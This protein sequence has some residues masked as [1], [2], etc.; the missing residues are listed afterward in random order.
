MKRTLGRWAVGALCLASC[1]GSCPGAAWAQSDRTFRDPRF[2]EACRNLDAK[3][4]AKARE[5]AERMLAEDPNSYTA[6]YIM[7]WIYYYGDGSIPR[8]NNCFR[9]A[10]QGLEKIW[11]TRPP[12][13]G[14]FFIHQMIFQQEILSTIQMERYEE[15]LRLIED[16]GKQYA[17]MEAY[18]G[19]PLLKLGRVDEARE[20]MKLELSLARDSGPLSHALNT[21]GNLEF[22]TDHMPQ[23]YDYFLRICKMFEHSR[24][25]DPVYWANAGETARDM[26][27][28]D[29]AEKLF[30]ESSR[31]FHQF[32]YSD[33]WRFLSEL[34]VSQ[35]RLAEAITALKE[36]QTWRLSCSPQVAQNKWAEAMAT[37]GIVL[38][39]LGYDKESYDIFERLSN[40]PDRNSGISTTSSL[41][42]GRNL[43]FYSLALR[44]YRQRLLEERSWSD[45]PTWFRLTAR[46]WRLDRKLSLAE[47]RASDLIAGG[48]GLIDLLRPYG[49]RSLDR[50]WLAPGIWH[51]FGP[52]PVAAA[53]REL[54]AQTPS[55]N[56]LQKT[57]LQAV[58]AETLTIQGRGSSKEAEELLSQILQELPSRDVA[59]RTRAQADMVRVMENQGRTQESLHYLRQVMERDPSLLRQF[60]LQLPIRWQASGG[61][62]SQ[63]VSR[64]QHSPRFKTSQGAFVAQ[65]QNDGEGLSARI[66]GPDGTIFK[67]L[68]SPAGK[69]TEET[70]TKFCQEF[71]DQLFAPMIDLTQADI[72]S[73]D[74]SPSTVSSKQVEK[75]LK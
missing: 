53:S 39:S 4:F 25:V 65:V 35:G 9:L 34:Y 37:A 21:L 60:E 11:G 33:P 24:D 20:K 19:W 58:L 50:P 51:L 72:Y 3:K 47:I 40:R 31:R 41:M 66:L 42:E 68:S 10:R 59:L 15:G 64:L 32:T 61:L 28:F 36:M 48:T 67:S 17:G 44:G 74:N 46:V 2:I 69:D 54:I 55:D 16:F 75:L 27:R 14:P 43:Y 13:N 1:L 71:H 23:S 30:L 29:E 18:K 56:K 73:I 8:A 7:G 63:A 12:N 38:L 49:P 22:E 52:G 62:A 5:I 45:W 26:L 57:Y 70:L 6:T